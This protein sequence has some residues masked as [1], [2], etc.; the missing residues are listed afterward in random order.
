MQIKEALIEAASSLASHHNPNLEARILLQHILNW[1]LEQLILQNDHILSTFQQT[2]Y[3]ELV[4]RRQNHEPIAYILG[5]KEFYGLNF[6]VSPIVLIPRPETELMIDAVLDL[7]DKNQN[8]RILDLGTG[9]GCI[10]ITLAASLPHARINA[11]D[12]SEEALQLAQQNAEAHMVDNR[13]KFINSNWF[14][15]LTAI[16][17][18]DFIV[19][20][21]P[22]ISENEQDNIA[23]ET[24]KFE[25]HTALFASTNGF[26]DYIKIAGEGR[27]FLKQNGKLIIEIGYLQEAE[28]LELFAGNGWKLDKI[29]KDLA[30]H[31]RCIVFV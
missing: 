24:I 1:S 27:Q 22:Y 2:Q 9:S 31:S 15:N 28:I 3:F 14:D 25:P 5:Y 17:K 21:P 26:S 19:S 18:F 29:H 20:N 4:N 12:I 10:A 13:V 8:Y 7:A 6:K 16:D 30:G 11:V 23:V